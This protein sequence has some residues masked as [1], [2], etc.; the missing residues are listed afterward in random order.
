MSDWIISLSKWDRLIA[1]KMPN[2]VRAFA[3]AQRA[4]QGL[5]GL[6]DCHRFTSLF[7][8][9]FVFYAMRLP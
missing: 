6:I 5:S 2:E 4:G 3:A 7:Y 1:P 8:I 9:A